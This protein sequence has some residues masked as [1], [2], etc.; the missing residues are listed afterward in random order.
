MEKLEEL[1]DKRGIVLDSETSSD[2]T[3]IMMEE[4]HQVLKKYAPDSFQRVFWQQ[5][6]KAASVKDKKGMRW[7]LSMIRYCIYL[8]HQSNKAY[9][10]L[11]HC[12]NLPSQRTLRDYTHSVKSTVGFSTEVDNQLLKAIGTQE[13]EKLVVIL[14]DEMY[15]REDLVYNKH[16]GQ[17]IGFV[18]L[19]DINS[20]LLYF[21]RQVRMDLDADKMP[22]AKTM[23]FFMVKSL[24]R[25]FRFPYA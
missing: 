4:E 24:F 15:I 20:N 13:W 17:L 21:E 19:G 14:M 6:K 9:E 18:N 3:Q 25:P 7:H 5:Q 11:H 8:R 1:I 23:M 10:T 12:N 22:L 16:T 2:F